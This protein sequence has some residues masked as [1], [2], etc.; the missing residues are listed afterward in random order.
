M[1]F[2]PESSHLDRLYWLVILSVSITGC[3]K[4]SSAE[5]QKNDQQPPKIEA[6]STME[7]EL[8]PPD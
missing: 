3:M 8:N 4:G 6:F 1:M 2:L 5:A 7:Q